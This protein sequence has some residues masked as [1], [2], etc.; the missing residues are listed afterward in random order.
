MEF[1]L[2]R[3]L[4]D[5]I[6]HREIAV[7]RE[8]ITAFGPVTAYERSRDRHDQ[9][10]ASAGDVATLACGAGCSWCC[11]FPVD[12]RPVEALSILAHMERELS[13]A[14]RE[15]VMREARA[16]RDL[17]ATLTDDER[18]RRNV[19]CPFLSAGRCTIYTARPQTCRNYHATSAAGCRESFEHPDNEDIDPEFAP[20]VYQSG[21]THVEAFSQAMTHA[22][23]DMRAYD[24]NAALVA[25]SEDLA[26]T[27]K[28]FEEREIVF[29][30]LE[31]VDVE[32][33]LMDLTRRS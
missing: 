31:S 12:V 15:R 32:P 11:Y 1:D 14:E 16:N 29:P 25:A 27:T 13:S 2:D 5:S 23:F 10:I 6:A 9:R 17:L 3:P 28:R 19:K 33:E 30:A 8:E 21:V 24:L 7:A 4:I 18:A 26:G 22:G 20:L